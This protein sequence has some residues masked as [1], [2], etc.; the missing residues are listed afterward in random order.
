MTYKAIKTCFWLLKDHQSVL[1]IFMRPLILWWYLV[2]KRLIDHLT[3]AVSTELAWASYM[4]CDGITSLL[5]MV[6]EYHS[7][8]DEN[9]WILRVKQFREQRF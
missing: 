9:S 4:A 2:P 8:V 7:V 3:A 5:E 1:Q 6:L